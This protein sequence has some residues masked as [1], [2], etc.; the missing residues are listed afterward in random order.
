[1]ALALAFLDLVGVATALGDEV[2]EV[3]HG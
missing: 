1:M 3:E 2:I